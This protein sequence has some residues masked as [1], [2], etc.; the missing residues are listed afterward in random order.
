MMKHYLLW[1]IMGSYRAA[2]GEHRDVILYRTYD[3]DDVNFEMERE[4][5]RWHR[6][7][8]EGLWITGVRVA[9]PPDSERYLIIKPIEEGY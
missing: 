8:Y 3:Q 5:D 1:Q 9:T 7:G 2:S 4:G 6:E